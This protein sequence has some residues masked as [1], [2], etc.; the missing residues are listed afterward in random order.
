MN[1]FLCQKGNFRFTE[2]LTIINPI[3]NVN[4]VHSPNFQNNLNFFF[5]DSG[6]LYVCI[7]VVKFNLVQLERCANPDTLL[8]MV[9]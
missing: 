6:S 5:A 4:S 9:E 3:V 8:C 1:G 7:S 2:V